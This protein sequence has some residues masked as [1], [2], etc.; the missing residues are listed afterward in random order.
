[1]GCLRKSQQCDPPHTFIHMNPFQEILDPPLKILFIFQSRGLLESILET[2]GS[3]R[4]ILDYLKVFFNLLLGRLQT[5]GAKITDIFMLWPLLDSEGVREIFIQSIQREGFK[6][7][8]IPKI[9]LILAAVMNYHRETIDG[10]VVDTNDNDVD[11]GNINCPQNSMANGNHQQSEGAKTTE[12]DPPLMTMEETLAEI[13]RLADIK[14]SLVKMF[15]YPY[16]V[17][18]FRQMFLGIDKFS[19]DDDMRTIIKKMVGQ[20]IFTLNAGNKSTTDLYNEVH[21]LNDVNNNAKCDAECDGK[22][23]KSIYQMNI[24]YSGQSSTNN[25][26]SV[27]GLDLEDLRSIPHSDH[28]PSLIHMPD[29]TEKDTL[30][31]DFKATKLLDARTGTNVPSLN[32]TPNTAAE[33]T[34]SSDF[35]ATHLRDAREGSNDSSLKHQPNCTAEEDLLGDINPTQLDDTRKYNYDS[36]E[37]NIEQ[38]S[39]NISISSEDEIGLLEKPIYDKDL[40]TS[41]DDDIDEVDED[42][43]LV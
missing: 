9:K 34:L 42:T 32:H 21:Y 39:D 10:L 6:E 20:V 22:G 25:D 31:R 2:E 18:K 17:R 3:S 24:T 33:E 7:S 27:V 43:L 37:V 36:S 19:L 28:D 14:P 15:E 41:A 4:Q 11:T 5:S 16:E 40:H 13:Q 38:E 30:L 12:T 8:N 1:M 35:K 29:N 26:M 23:D